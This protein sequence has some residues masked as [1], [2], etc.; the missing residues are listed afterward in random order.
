MRASELAAHERHL[1]SVQTQ[2]EASAQTATAQAAAVAECHD[3][4]DLAAILDPH[5][6]VAIWRRPQ[7][8]RIADLLR[9]EDCGV[10]RHSR[11]VQRSVELCGARDF[12]ELVP[13]AARAADP[14]GA[15]ALAADV[16]SLCE[17]FTQLVCADELMVSL[18]SP[19]EA[20]CPRFHVDLVGIRMLV[21]YVGPGTEWLPHEHVDRRWLGDA[22]HGRRDEQTG[23]MLPGARVQQVAPF[24][25]VLLKGEAWPGAAGFGAVHRSPDPAGQPRVLLRVD[26]L[27]QAAVE[28]EEEQG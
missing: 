6:H 5:V 28:M 1:V 19:D 4:V 17:M 2:N 11:L 10:G 14:V 26:M 8:R 23:L 22:G 20:T 13:A 21:T 15:D 12:R 27:N 7:D 9:R 16:A 25:V 3:L 24:D 18:E